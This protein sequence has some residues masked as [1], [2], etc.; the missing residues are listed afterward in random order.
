MAA[1]WCRVYESNE[2][3]LRQI[4]TEITEASP[5]VDK[6]FQGEILAVRA[7]MPPLWPVDNAIQWANGS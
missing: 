6:P 2:Q 4:V 5:E 3:E 1:A 7:I